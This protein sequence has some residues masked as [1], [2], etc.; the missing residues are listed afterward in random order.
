MQCTL[1][2]NNIISLEPAK[3]FSMFISIRIS[4]QNIIFSYLLISNYSGFIWNFHLNDS[5]TPTGFQFLKSRMRSRKVFHLNNRSTSGFNSNNFFL[6][7]PNTLSNFLNNF[8][9]IGVLLQS[10]TYQIFQ[11]IYSCV[12]TVSVTTCI[13][14]Q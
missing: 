11:E 4:L 1:S 14:S 2:F 3:P 8:Q 9:C 5:I 13:L 7:C 6:I 10:Q 12:R